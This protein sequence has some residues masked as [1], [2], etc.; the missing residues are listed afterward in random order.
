MWI[1]INSFILLIGFELNSSIKTVRRSDLFSIFRAK[2]EI[3]EM[4]KKLKKEG[5]K[6][7]KQEALPPEH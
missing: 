4:Q 1:Y 6:Q 2:E 5:E 3:K 7:F